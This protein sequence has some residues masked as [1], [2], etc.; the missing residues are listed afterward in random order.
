MHWLEA[1]GGLNSGAVVA[2]AEDGGPHIHY[3]GETRPIL[4]LPEHEDK[5]L[6]TV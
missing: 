6:L 1:I 2:Q 4:P 5:T 3:M